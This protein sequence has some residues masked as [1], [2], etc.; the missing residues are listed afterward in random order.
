VLI[1][2]VAAH[3]SRMRVGSGGVMLQHYSALK[4]AENFRML[5][6]LFPGR[7]DLGI[8][9]APGTD[10]RTSRAL[11]DG[12]GAPGLDRFPD[13]IADVLAFLR[14]ELPDDHPHRGVRCMPAGPTAPEVWLLGSSDASAALAA[15]HGVGFSFAHFINADGGEEVTQAYRRYFRPSAWLA[16]PHAS[17]AVFAICAE[18]ETEAARLAQ[19]RDLALLRLY[20]GRFGPYPSVEE[21]EA[22][23]YTPWDLQIVEHNR[24]RIV[25][26]TPP[27]V[28]A[29]LLE[30]AEA[31]GADEIVVVTITHD[32]KARA[33]SYELLAEAFA[34]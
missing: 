6:T 9:R 32:V 14:N 5:E 27:V 34:L 23:A 7:I 30:H 20:T 26:G 31:Y 24:R 13:Q 1:G 11:K 25:A 17:V 10:G 29:R 21:A 15:H 28:K 12:G 4:V 33:R 18:T 2:Q 16:E 8:G 3:T 22:Y 19:S